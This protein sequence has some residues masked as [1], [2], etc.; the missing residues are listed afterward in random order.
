MLCEAAKLLVKLI[1]DGGYILVVGVVLVHFPQ[2][3]YLRL[4]P[5]HRLY[6]FIVCMI[7]RRWIMTMHNRC[8]TM[9]FCGSSSLGMGIRADKMAVLLAVWMMLSGMSGAGTLLV[10]AM[11]GHA[12]R[13]DEIIFNV[14]I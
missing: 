13:D 8:A 9:G 2:A 4:H 3:L 12:G 6:R 7:A 5:T 11:V 1:T 14:R 10:C